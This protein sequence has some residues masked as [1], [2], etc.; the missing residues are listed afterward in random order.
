[1]KKPTAILRPTAVLAAAVTLAACGGGGSNSSNPVPTVNSGPPAPTPVAVVGTITGFGSVYVDGTRYE[2]APDTLVDIEDQISTM[3]DDSA[4]KLGM[5]VRV[6]SLD[7][8]GN[9]VATHIEYD[10]DL[11]GPIE[12]ISVDATDPSL[13]SISILGLNVVIDSN[14]V[15]DDDIG[16]NDGQAGIDIRDLAV[17]MVIEVSGFPTD[18]GYLA[19][20][21]DRQLDANGNNPSVGSPNVDDDELEVKGFVESIAADLSAITVMG[22]EFQVNAGTVFDDGLLL[23]DELIGVFVEVKADFSGA[24]LVAREIEREDDLDFDNDDDDDDDRD[25]EFEI[26]GIL[27]SIDVSS[28][29]NTITIDGLTLAVADASAFAN[30]VGSRIEV[31]GFF[32]ADGILSPRE[33]DREFENNVELEDLVSSVDLNG[34]S[35]TTRLGLTVTAT[36]ASR[37]EDDA[38]FDDDDRLTPQEF[39][40]RLQIG[41]RIEAKGYTTDGGD[42]VWNRIERDESAGANDDFE[43]ELTGPVESI[44]GDAAAFSLV[45]QGVTVLTDQIDND[46]FEDEF[47]ISIGRTAFFERL[48]VGDLIEAESFEGDSHC[49]PG[50][51][52]ARELEREFPDSN[53]SSS[54]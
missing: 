50:M 26:E 32:N 42:V 28:T 9:R 23:N 46:D 4:L 47:D 38:S 6:M 25:N 3:G 1:M 33:F 15:F 19:T 30:L 54:D 22:I 7:N 37:V 5:K 31:K 49:T 43:C 17:G 35:F 40:N 11:R 10:D 44:S 51:L 53:N 45:I 14:T 41:D 36:G 2:V 21:I 48:S 18:D 16:N 24:D 13:G 27:Q 39:V 8:A 12:S 20:R 34:V 52:N 29:P